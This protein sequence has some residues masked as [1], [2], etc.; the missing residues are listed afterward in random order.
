MQTVLLDSGK[1]ALARAIAEGKKIKTVAYRV[2]QAVNFEPQPNATNVAPVSVYQGTAATIDTSLVNGDEVR[3][4][5]TLLEAE[6]PFNVGNIMLFLQD[7]ATQALIPYLYG[8]MPVAVPKYR[9]N[10]PATV[11]NR[12]VFNMTAKYTNVSEAFSLSVVTPVYAS[13]PNYTN[14]QGLPNPGQASYQQSIL[15]NNTS[16]GSPALAMRRE[17]DNSWFINPFF[18]RL[19]SPKFG[20]MDGGIVGDSYLPFYGEYYAGGFYVT[21]LAGFDRFLDGGSS[22]GVPGEADLPVDGGTYE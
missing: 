15:Q 2:G 20:A 10:P 12:L 8:V 9:N 21:P 4:T 3:Y 13:L 22:W 16:T 11:G 17:L 5:I 1:A 7:D 14:E 18:Q 6:G 19:D